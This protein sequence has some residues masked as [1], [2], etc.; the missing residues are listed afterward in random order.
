MTGN[1]NEIR[2]YSEYILGIDYRKSLDDM[3][4]YLT[5]QNGIQVLKIAS[6]LLVNKIMRKAGI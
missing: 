2:E 6:L 1:D 4:S 3:R 5:P